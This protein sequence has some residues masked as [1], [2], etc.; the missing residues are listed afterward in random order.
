MEDAQANVRE[1][2]RTFFQNDEYFKRLEYIFKASKL[3]PDLFKMIDHFL[4]KQ[5]YNVPSVMGDQL[6]GISISFKSVLF[7]NKKAIFDV[8]ADEGS[9]PLVWKGEK[10]PL[11]RLYPEKSE[12]EFTVPV[13]NVLRFMIQI[14]ADKVFWENYQDIRTTYETNVSQ[15][16]RSYIKTHRDRISS[17]KHRITEEIL[18]DRPA[19]MATD[20]ADESST[21]L[22]KEERDVLRQRVAE[23]ERLA[24]IKRRLASIKRPRRT[25]KPKKTEYASFMAL[26]AFDV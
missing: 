2:C 15:V 14:D 17:I 3:I 21:E 10:N 23:E 7:A 16:K 26:G 25:K 18:R 13:M 19:A 20:D 9:G 5:D 8:L 24:R 11:F 4:T 1:Q 12:V 6:C 22:T